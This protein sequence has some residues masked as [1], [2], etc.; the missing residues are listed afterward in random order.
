MKVMP[1][2]DILFGNET[3]RNCKMPHFFG[4]CSRAGSHIYLVVKHVS[5][6]MPGSVFKLY[7]TTDKCMTVTTATC[8]VLCGLVS[9]VLNR[10]AEKPFFSVPSKGALYQQNISV[11]SKEALLS[12]KH[13]STK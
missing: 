9:F 2:V 1:Y 7:H 12:A 4:L 8:Y 3:V 6:W 10:T 13:F 11:P 5:I